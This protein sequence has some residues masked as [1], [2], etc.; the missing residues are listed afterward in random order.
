MHAGGEEHVK[1][2]I[3]GAGLSGVGMSIAL[4]RDGCEDFV[5]LERADDLGGTWRD[6]SYPGCLRYPQR[7]LLVLGRT[8]PRLESGLR[9]SGGDRGV[10]T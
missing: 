3:A 10:H 6:N 9:R 2:A 8:E 4:K 1:I 7:P 5:V